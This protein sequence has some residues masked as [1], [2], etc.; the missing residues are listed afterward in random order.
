MNERFY[1]DPDDPDPHAV[2]EYDDSIDM[3]ERERTITSR[4][5]S[6]IQNLTKDNHF[7]KSELV[8]LLK[9]ANK[10]IQALS[11]QMFC[12]DELCSGLLK[13]VCKSCGKERTK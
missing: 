2:P 11:P 9:D 3:H 8:E 6:A 10:E 12:K 4:I 13:H 1:P 5:S 7:D